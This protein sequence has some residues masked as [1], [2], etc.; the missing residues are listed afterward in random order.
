MSDDWTAAGWSLSDAPPGFKIFR[1]TGDLALVMIDRPSRHNALTLSMWAA[2]PALLSSLG[3]VRALLLA[4]ARSTF[5][6]GADIGELQQIY[7]DPSAAAEF[8]AT[9]VAAEIALASFAAPTIAVVRGSCVGGGCQL[10]VA[11]D[12]RI[13][14]S[15]ARFGVTPAKLGV[16]YAAVPTVRLAQLVGPSR[17]KYLLFTAELIDAS[18]ALTYGL[19]DEVVPADS[20]ISRASALAATIGSRS[21]QT[22]GAVSA[23]LRAAA[24]GTS[25][26]NAITPYLEQA[27]RDPD[28]AEGLA[29]FLERR[30]PR[31]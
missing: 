3:P 31:F 5:S 30:Q 28:V 11:C 15:D 21:R 10:A 26:D 29:A 9:N 24:D 27:R 20:L 22:I 16:V 7:A 12:L 18:T 2:F 23:V 6:A 14:S 13:A 4:G 17:A 8:H 25:I 19:V 1:R